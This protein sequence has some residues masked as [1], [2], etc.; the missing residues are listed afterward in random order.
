MVTTTL[1]D[2]FFSDFNAH[3]DEK[4]GVIIIALHN[5]LSVLQKQRD[6]RERGRERNPI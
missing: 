1:A 2:L 6:E 3:K 4:P 5:G